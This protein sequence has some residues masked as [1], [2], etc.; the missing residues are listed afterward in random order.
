MKNNQTYRLLNGINCPGDLRKLNVDALPEV[1]RELRQDIIDELSCNPGHFAA[2]LGAVDLT[3]AL[4]YVFNTP[5]D[6]IVWDVGHQAYAHKILTG[7][8]KAFSTNRKLKGIKPFPSPEESEYDT[9]TCGHASNSIS[10][11]LGMCVAARHKGEKDRHVVAVIGDGSMTGGLAFEGLNNVAAIP[12]NVLIVLNDNN[13]A[14]DR[15]VGGM[16]EYLLN[17]TTTN[18]YNRIRQRIA[19]QLFHWG[20]LNDTRR[21]SLI[22]FNN[23]LKSLLSQQQ[24]IFEGMN[25]RYF[26]PFDGNDVKNVARVLNDIKDMEGPKLLH[27][28]TVKGKGFEPAE[29]AATEWHAPGLFDKET[30]ERIVTSTKGMPPLFQEVF[31]H[32]VLELAKNNKKIIGVTPAMPSGC[33][34][35]IMMKE[36]PDR[37]F[38]VGIAEGHAVTF[39]GGMAQD[40]L[41][42]F[43]NIYSSFMQRAYDNVIHDVAIQKLNVVFCLDRAG[44]VGEDGPTHHGAFDLAYM[45]CIPNLTIASP[46]NE[47]ELRKLMYTAQLPDMGPFVIRYPRGRGTLVDW[48]C[49]FEEIQIGKGRKLKDGN[50]LAVITLGP[51]GTLAKKAIARAEEEGV[52]IAHYDLRFLKPLDEELLHE[53]GKRFSKIV[54]IED[55]VTEG[56]MGSAILE[57]MMDHHYSPQITRIGIPNIFVEHGS[58]KELFKLCHMDEESIYQTLKSQ[59]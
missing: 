27:L 10:A 9:F 14:I 35:N 22:R 4:H 44:L 25:I 51:I 12:N 7:R 8:R 11:A 39:S 48:K 28:H 47:H 16:K 37:A 42:P 31:G 29:K 15:T 21:K 46:Y 1:C 32:T 59:L 50:D 6:R 5:Y 2:S 57:F 58:V 20:I 53:V 23:S 17:L 38:D 55:G 45:R 36:M 56:G 33:S 52:T 40:G 43:C 34:L 54:T 18:R 24:N 30:G 19:R 13:M 26:G 49:E 3:V 41:L